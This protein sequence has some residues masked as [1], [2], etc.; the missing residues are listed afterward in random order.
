[1]VH[2]EDDRE[3]QKSSIDTEPDLDN[4]ELDISAR[5]TS[6]GLVIRFNAPLALLVHS[7]PRLTLAL[8]E[9]MS[10]RKRFLE[11]QRV[12]IE[13]PL[14]AVDDVTS[15]NDVACEL[16]LLLEER[17]KIVVAEVMS[18][19][20]NDLIEESTTVK[21]KG[22][23]NLIKYDF[24]RRVRQDEERDAV[25]KEE[26]EE[27]VSIF[28][29]ALSILSDL[30]LNA[31]REALIKDGKLRASGSLTGGAISYTT[32]NVALGRVRDGS[33]PAS[34]DEPDAR[35]VFATLR[36]GQRFKT[37]H[38]IILVGDV[39]PGAEIISGGDIFVLGSL[40]G[41]AHAG[42]SEESMEEGNERI[43][44]ALTLEATQLRIGS[45]ITRGSEKSPF[46]GFRAS[47]RSRAVGARRRDPEIAR[48]D[49]DTIV[50]GPFY[51]KKN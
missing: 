17:Y 49:G 50:V 48:V 13:V 20:G 24:N 14:P 21:K 12:N 29:G 30:G 6:D 22:S 38:S 27:E 45:I 5:G 10:R 31:N 9:F 39:K 43:I 16:K 46:E 51:P 3:I 19:G 33:D 28:D 42:A 25:L 18:F 34:W 8:D 4:N 2:G 23:A 11:G 36:S 15:F 32:S 41:V 26:A 44:F 1:M 37:A 35:I 7:N 47:A 40:N